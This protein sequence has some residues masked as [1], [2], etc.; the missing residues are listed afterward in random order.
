[1]TKDEMK[2]KISMELK[3][4]KDMNVSTKWHDLQ[5]NPNDLPP[6]EKGT[7]TIDVL[8][9]SGRI[10][11][12]FYD[13]GCWYDTSYGVEIYPPKAWCEIPIFDYLSVVNSFLK[14]LSHLLRRL[15]QS[16]F[17]NDCLHDL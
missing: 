17:F 3:A 10:A 1:M 4:G 5:K 14:K 12:Y 8:T 15:W 16:N 9:D 2:N 13:E 7:V 6:T 11:Y